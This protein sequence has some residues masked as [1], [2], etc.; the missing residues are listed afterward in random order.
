MAIPRYRLFRIVLILSVLIILIFGSRG[1]PQSSNSPEFR[2]WTVGSGGV[3]ERF[4]EDFSQVMRQLDTGKEKLNCILLTI[5]EKPFT[6]EQI[7]E[8]TGLPGLQVSEL[9]S[10]LNSINLIK[11]DN[12]D[13]WAT[14]VPVITNIQMKD[15][16]EKLFPM[17]ENAANYL[18]KEMTQL[19]SLYDRSKTQ[20]D[21]SWNSITHYLFD[22]LIIDGS[23]HRSINNLEKSRTKR[24]NENL[25][26]T[27]IPLFFFELGS[28]YSSLGSNWYAFKKNNKQREINILH[29]P[30]FNRHNIPMEKYRKSREFRTAYFKITPD[31]GIDDLNKSEKKMFAELG[32][33]NTK[34]LL[35]P[36]IKNTTILPIMAELTRMGKE[37]ADIAFGHFKV[38]IDSFENGPYSKFLDGNM[39][40]IQVCY[41]ILFGMVVERLIKNGVV[42]EIPN[43]VPE[44][45]GVYFVFG[46]LY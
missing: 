25:Q 42:P 46:K 28:N 16:K 1:F 6:E 38:I 21:P 8:R 18:K 22:K 3:K 2:W 35:V 45:F 44:S 14:T 9:I 27:G 12:H 39:D 33:I 30:V 11:K 43:P 7:I 40:Y 20:L 19:K 4:G 23:F 24:E 32:W 5:A 31:G 29:G 15:I 36:I 13:R 37:A 34:F 41:H 17:A 26:Q 10:K